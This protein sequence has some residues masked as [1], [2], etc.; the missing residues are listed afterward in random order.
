MTVYAKDFGSPLQRILPKSS[1]EFG[2][3]LLPQEFGRDRSTT[4]RSVGMVH[5]FSMS[6]G[7]C[8][9]RRYGFLTGD[10]SR[11]D[12]MIKFEGKRVTD[13]T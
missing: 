3:G 8:I 10:N 13:G 7:P 9:L 2:G 12:L 5:L 1:A 4:G 6:S 11:L